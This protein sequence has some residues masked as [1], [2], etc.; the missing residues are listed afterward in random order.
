MTC[1]RDA[2]MIAAACLAFAAS[3]AVIAPAHPLEAAARPTGNQQAR[4]A[5]PGLLALLPKAE[6]WKAADEPRSYFPENLF[7]Y[8]DGAAESYLAYDFKELAVAE[9]GRTGSKATM[10]VEIYDMAGRDN[11]FG[12]FAAERYPENAP[13]DIGVAGYIEGEVL[14]FVADR[15]YV[16]LLAFDAGDGVRD[17]L[18]RFAGAIA[19]SAGGS[20]A[21]PELLARLPEAGRVARSE[22]YIRVNF[23]GFEF[24]KD[25]WQAAYN[26]GGEEYE[27]FFAPCASAAEAGSSLKRL[28][29]FYGREGTPAEKSNGLWTVKSRQGKLTILGLSGRTL[30]GASGVAEAARPAAVAGVRAL[31]AATAGAA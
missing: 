1:R 27:A 2:L 3:A 11:A 24:L 29:D 26:A 4:A 20:R 18:T 15:Y 17:V 7:E 21:L 10:T 28:L 6:G 14:N 19:A 13:V 30:C 16:K 12:I 25:A 31:M 23:M 8:I 22:R 5:D 9:Y